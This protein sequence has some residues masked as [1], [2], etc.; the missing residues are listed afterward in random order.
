MLI[1]YKNKYS[2]VN[3]KKPY[4]PLA[5]LFS[6]ILI[7]SIGYRIIWSDYND[8]ILD[9][10]YMTFM[11]ITTIGFDEVYPLDSAGQIFTIFISIGGVGSLFYIMGIMM[12]NLFIMQQSNIRIRRALMKKISKLNDHVILIGHGRVGKLAAKALCDRGIDCVI[13]DESFENKDELENDKNIFAI[14]ADATDDEVLKLAGIEKASKM[15]VSTG[16]AATTVFV[17]LSAKVLKPDIYI[18]ARS[19]DDS[20]VSKLRMAGADR[21]V[22]PYS[23]GGQRLADFV[24]NP[25]LVDFIEKGFAHGVS[26]LSIEQLQIPPDSHCI[27]RSMKELDIR[28]KSG[29]TILAII[30]DDTPILNPHGDFTLNEGDQLVAMGNTEQLSALNQLMISIQ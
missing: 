21:I 28:K 24:I 17:V 20:V 12:E 5:L 25:Y 15:I 18:I 22:N 16:N 27:N 13:I 3:L 2:H 6:V 10:I 29:A 11:T 23:I 4:L 9:D 26:G 7:G 1:N 14:E 8:T 19:D 30:R